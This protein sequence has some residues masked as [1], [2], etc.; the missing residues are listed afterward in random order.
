MSSTHGCRFQRC[1]PSQLDPETRSP[2]RHHHTWI[3]AFPT[4]RL[5]RW[6]SESPPSK[7]WTHGCNI[8]NV[9]RLFIT[10]PAQQ[11]PDTHV[12]NPQ[13]WLWLRG[14]LRPHQIQRRTWRCKPI[15]CSNSGTRRD[16]LIGAPSF[17]QTQHHQT[18][19]RLVGGPT[20]G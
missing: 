16:F 17:S 3:S 1:P 13:T 19:C 12:R 9:G 11:S 5:V 14:S 4:L 20:T 8:R 15:M 18:R 10:W 7:Q 2:S 6:E